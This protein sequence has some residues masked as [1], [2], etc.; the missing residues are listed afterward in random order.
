MVGASANAQTPI[1]DGDYILG[2]SFVTTPPAGDVLLQELTSA[3]S[4]TAAADPK[5]G[6]A[7]S[8]AGNLYSAVFSSNGGSTRDFFYQFT[9]N[10][11]TANVT[12]LGVSNFSGYSAS[13]G[14]STATDI[15]GTGNAY[16]SPFTTG[17]YSSASA[18]ESSGS[19]SFFYDSNGSF[20]AA[21]AVP[22]GGESATM[23][24]QTNATG[25]TTNEGSIQASVSANAL[26]LAPSGA[27]APEPASLALIVP[28][29]LGAI[30]LARRRKS[31]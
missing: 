23:F 27:A 9:V 28:G 6:I 22:V 20:S 2:V 25:F 17:G 13:I 1:H 19:I 14:Q 8:I 21:G 3:Y 10:S 16:G 5:T 24:I 18:M 12:T 30:G 26:I 29:V 4:F 31:A 11:G 7:E 15:D